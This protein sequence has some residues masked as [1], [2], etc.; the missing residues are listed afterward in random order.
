MKSSEELLLQVLRNDTAYATGCTDPIGIALAGA[1]AR[2]NITGTIHSISIEVSPNIF[3]NAM[4]V[5]IPGTD[6]KGIDYAAAMGIVAGEADAGLDVLNAVDSTS[7]EQAANL[8]KG[9]KTEVSISSNG[10]LLFIS[11]RLDTDSGWAQA[12]IQDN[13]DRIVQIVKNGENLL[14]SK[15]AAAAS[16]RVNLESITVQDVFDFAASVPL[17]EVK[18]L[19]EGARSNHAAAIKGVADG[20]SFGLGKAIGGLNCSDRIMN[21][22][23]RARSYTAGASDAR[24]AGL[25]VRIMAVAGSGNHGITALLSV[26]AVWEA[27]GLSEEALIRGL[28]LSA[29]MTIYIKWHV[30]RMSAFCGCAVAAATGAAAGITCMLGGN[31]NQAAGAMESIMGCLTGMICDGAKETC[32]YKVSVAAGEAVLHSYLALQGISVRSPVG[33]LSG[34]L[35]QSFINM[36][37][38]NDPGMKET[39]KVI[40]DIARQIQREIIDAR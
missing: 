31:E 4:G 15:S 25:P 17:E 36:G 29:L 8:L 39:D 34:S 26:Y 30:Q 18:Y 11:V 19:A 24:M 20:A 23:L 14:Q 7:S 2:A 33:I 22:Y 38:I 13:Y 3:K 12:V 16:K 32:S 5:G 28:V 6:H 37:L 27:E 10:I 1:V 35:K 9:A 40:L 21:S